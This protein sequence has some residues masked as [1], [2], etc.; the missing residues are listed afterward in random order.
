MGP[1]RKIEEGAKES[2]KKKQPGGQKYLPEYTEK[3][4]ILTRYEGSEYRIYCN[5]CKSDFGISHAGKDDCKD[6]WRGQY[7]RQNIKLINHSSVLI[8]CMQSADLMKY[9]SN[10]AWATKYTMYASTQEAICTVKMDMQN[11][12]TS[13]YEGT[14]TR[15][16]T[17]AARKPQ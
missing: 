12:K 13:C 6:T 16:E 7:T 11:R 9:C 2:A 1:K 8:L 15:E 17:K 4:P 3:Y 5:A 14:Y 10:S